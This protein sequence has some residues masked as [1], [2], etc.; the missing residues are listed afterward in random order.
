MEWGVPLHQHSFIVLSASL[1]IHP[2]TGRIR[3]VANLMS[4]VYA[5]AGGL[6]ISSYDHQ[7]QAAR[8]SGHGE[9]I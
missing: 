2:V 1:P 6:V 5:F 9:V 3:I 7:R 8:R 4:D